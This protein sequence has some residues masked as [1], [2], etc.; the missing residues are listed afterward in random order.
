MWPIIRGNATGPIPVE[1]P[2][3]PDGALKRFLLILSDRIFER[4]ERPLG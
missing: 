3:G 1:N 4:V 2:Q